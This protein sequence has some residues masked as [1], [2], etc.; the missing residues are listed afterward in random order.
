MP[1]FL[2]LCIFVGFAT[3]PIAVSWTFI[4]VTNALVKGPERRRRE[5]RTKQYRRRSA[6]CEGVEI[7]PH[8]GTVFSCRCAGLT[9]CSDRLRTRILWS[10]FDDLTAPPLRRRGLTETG[11][12]LATTVLAVV[13]AV[14][15]F[16][17]IANG[18]L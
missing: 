18:W 10:E 9:E 14:I 3:P 2:A 6:E 8:G 7:C 16:Q 17:A 5:R 15:F 1:A 13:L 12:W 11:E 4:H